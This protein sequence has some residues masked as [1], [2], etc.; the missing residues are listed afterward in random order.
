MHILFLTHY[1]PPE[2]N[3][4]AS[5]TYENAIRWVG[6]GQQVSVITCVPHHPKGVVYDGYQ[7]RWR[8][9]ELMEGIHVLRV[10]TYLGPNAGFF[11]RIANYV[12]YLLAAT[13]FCRSVKDVDIVVSTSPQFFCGLAGYAVSKRLNVPWLLEIRDLWPESIVAV[14]ALKSRSIISLLEGIESFMYRKADGIVSVT[15]SFVDHIVS[16]GVEREK[17]SVVTNGADLRRFDPLP[18][19]N[20]VAR[21]LGLADRFVAAFIGTHGMAHGLETV[22]LAAERLRKE[23]N[24]LFLLV[25]DGAEREN[26]L[27]QKE[28]LQL[29]NVLML[30]QQSKDRAV[31]LLAS[32]DVSLVLLRK[33]R[34]FRTVIPSKIFEAMAM[35]RPIILGVDGESKEI[36]LES[37]AGI[38]IEPENDRE[39]ADAVLTLYRDRERC[40]EMG[41]RG[42]RF[43]ERNYSRDILARRYLSLIEEVISGKRSDGREEVV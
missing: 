24:I 12:S 42:R 19:D 9:W 17:V 4:P 33:N 36:M 23:N 11:R 26:I 40:R 1:F 5:R 28:R 14:G 30:P 6:E 34:L 22:L 27:R 43:V 10:K 3:A 41:Q 29:D 8:Q 7:N 31:K 39:L 35:E 13:L 37:G 20:P 21:E 16:R 25:G 2:V 32:A 38:C 18:K 15:R